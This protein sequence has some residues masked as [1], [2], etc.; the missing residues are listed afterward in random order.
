MIIHYL[1]DGTI[2]GYATLGGS[3][4]D[5]I[6]DGEH[7]LVWDGVT[8]EPLFDYTVRN[9]QVVQKSVSERQSYQ[10]S[11]LARSLR[12]QRDALL[13]QSDYVILPDVPNTCLLYTSPSPRDS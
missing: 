10:D 5:E 11:I 3:I 8:P 13:A 9:N 6:P 12:G 4:P 1:T 7:Y 2:L